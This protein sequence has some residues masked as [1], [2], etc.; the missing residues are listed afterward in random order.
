MGT[1]LREAD[2]AECTKENRKSWE[3]EPWLPPCEKCHRR[4]LVPP[5]LRLSRGVSS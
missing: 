1:I 4:A 3:P 5:Q 2:A